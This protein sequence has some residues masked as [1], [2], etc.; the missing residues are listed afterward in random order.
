MHRRIARILVV[1]L[2]FALA[3]VLLSCEKK[4]E[5]PLITTNEVG[6]P[7]SRFIN[8]TALK[9]DQRPRESRSTQFERARL[10]FH[11]N[12]EKYSR[13]IESKRSEFEIKNREVNKLLPDELGKAIRDLPDDWGIPDWE[14]IKELIRFI[15]AQRLPPF[16]TEYYKV[17]QGLIAL[18]QG[19]C[20]PDID[21]LSNFTILPGA[22]VE[23]FGTC[24]DEPLGK[25]IMT[26]TPDD[27][28]LEL[29]VLSWSETYILA[30]MNH[31][32]SSLRPNDG[33]IWIE[34]RQ[35]VESNAW[36]MHFVPSMSTWVWLESRDLG[37]GLFGDSE[38]GSLFDD[39]F[40]NDIDFDIFEVRHEHDGDGWSEFRHPWAGD[41][42]MEQGYHIGVAAL[43]SA[44]M[45]A[46][47]FMKGPKG[48][49][50]P[51][52]ASW[53]CWWNCAD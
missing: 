29:E 1:T 5:P 10:E 20:D 43:D 23:I 45:D 36:P 27:D 44:N 42:K 31:L 13:E 41:Q 9:P 25:V 19:G 32:V 24:F 12:F 48:I 8:P 38:N 4:R 26:V 14:D 2:V 37:G 33:M 52:T 28:T 39:V 7:Q 21:S 16:K 3:S 40:L 47:Y 49:T 6:K 50:P 51:S 46:F 30:Q 17:H 53:D 22:G 15:R 34:T 18:A 11:K 35:G